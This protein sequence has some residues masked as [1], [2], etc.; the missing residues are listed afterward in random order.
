MKLWPAFL[1]NQ[2][3]A[4]ILLHATPIM[5]IISYRSL[6]LLASTLKIYGPPA[7]TLPC[8]LSPPQIL[9]LGRSY[10]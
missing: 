9:L 3:F 10:T 8:L 1:V 4:I 5:N 2:P 6:I 7:R